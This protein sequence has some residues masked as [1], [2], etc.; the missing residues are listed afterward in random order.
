[1]QRWII[2]RATVNQSRPSGI[3]S[4]DRSNNPLHSAEGKEMNKTV[5]GKESTSKDRRAHRN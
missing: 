4:A 2:D 3:L 1:V 5:A